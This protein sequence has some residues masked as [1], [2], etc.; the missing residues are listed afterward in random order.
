M[1]GASPQLDEVRRL[2]GRY[3]RLRAPV[4][5]RGETGVG[6]ELVA[7][8]LHERGPRRQASFVDRNC[9]CL[10]PQLAESEL[11]G[12]M[13]GAFTG[14]HRDREG[15]FAL[16]SGGTLFLDEVGE[17]ALPLQAKL[18][19]ALETGR[20]RPVG[21][22]H[23]RAIDVRVVAAT[24]RDLEAMVRQRTFREDL[25]HRLSIL[26]VEVPPL[27]ARPDDIAP[28]LNH[29]CQRAAAELGHP[30]QLTSEAVEVATRFP[31]PGN[32]RA[33]RNAVL[34]AAARHGGVIGPQTLLEGIPSPSASPPSAEHHEHHLPAPPMLSIPR[35]DYRTMNLML[36]RSY[37]KEH[38]SINKAA[39]ALGIPRST[40]SAWLRRAR[41]ST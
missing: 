6:K 5:V 34:R 27:R 40:L 15:A 25:Y 33:L 11:F 38:G 17:L 8:A 32:V 18:L 19:R 4:L 30:V 36:L 23:A 35:G 1:V 31:W 29:F 13:R 26:T 7:R 16:A 24:H 12:H 41:D 37:V 10:D 9:A 3:A 14:A 22:E 2:V 21:A 28:L 20:V 39:Q